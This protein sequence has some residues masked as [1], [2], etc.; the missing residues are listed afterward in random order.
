MLVEIRG[1]IRTLVG[2]L[3]VV[4]TEVFEFTTSNIFTLCTENVTAIN[5]V[6]ING[7]ELGS[8]ETYSFNSTTNELTLTATLTSGDNIEVKFT[9]YKFS[10]TELDKYIEAGL[11]Y[12]SMF[13]DNTD[14]DWEIEDEEIYPTPNNKEED[15][16]A[17]VASILIKP[18]YSSYK[19][20][21]VTVTYPRSMTK[22]ERIVELVTRFF[23]GNGLSDNLEWEE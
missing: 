2:D 18:D 23:R 17:L 7:N 10:E 13:A 22:E 20:S 1:K 15:L 8:G 16:I 14:D 12:I 9:S 11:V 19:L 6:K 21:N 4:N 3:G 5:S